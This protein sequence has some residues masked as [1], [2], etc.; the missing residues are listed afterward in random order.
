MAM[1]VNAQ[2]KSYE[3]K[4]AGNKKKIYR[5]T[6]DGVRYFQ[7]VREYVNNMRARVPPAR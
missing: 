6:N 7:A 2:L 5:Q 4:K 1:V 3:L